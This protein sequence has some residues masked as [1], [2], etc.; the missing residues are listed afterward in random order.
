[1]DLYYLI[2]SIIIIIIIIIIV[3]NTNYC[4]DIFT[5]YP[6]KIN[7][8]HQDNI[9]Q[10]TNN[11]SYLVFT[12]AGDNTQFYDHWLEE[13]R[14]YDVWVVYYGK[15]DSNYDMYSKVVDRIWKRKGGKY[16]NF[17]YIYNNYKDDL[18]KYNRFFLVDDDIVMSTTDINNLFDISVKYNLLVCQPAFTPESKISIPYLNRVIKGNILRYTSFVENNTPVFS[19]YALLEFMKYYDPILIGWGIDYLYIWAL[20][21][22]KKDKYAII[23]SIECYNPPDTMKTNTTR[24]LNNIENHNNEFDYWIQI[25]NKYN[26]PENKYETYSTI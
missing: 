15:S 13:N 19:K 9:T 17:H 4:S 22:D 25:K 1:M 11:K 12:S 20:G 26:I 8:E 6:K 10:D 18:M 21:M 2:I 3:V 16:Q 7:R 24:E 23:D 14:N 5:T